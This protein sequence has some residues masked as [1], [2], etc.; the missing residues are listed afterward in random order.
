[1]DRNE[2]MPTTRLPTGVLAVSMFLAGGVLAW[3]TWGTWSVAS[4]SGV[5]LALVGAFLLLRTMIDWHNA[6]SASNRQ[7]SEQSEQLVALNSDLDQRIE[8][9]QEEVA[10]RI[11]AESRV[12]SLNRML[13]AIRDVNQLIARVT[14]RQR[15]LEGTC[16][17]LRNTRG[18]RHAWIALLDESHKLM[19][20]AE[21]GLDED[22]QALVAQMEAGT[23][24]AAVEQTLSQ[25]GVT[26]IEAPARAFGAPQMARRCLHEGCALAARL[27]CG[28]RI[29]G[30]MVACLDETEID[31]EELTLFGNTADD[32]AFALRSLEL[33][34]EQTRA[35][36]ALRLERSKLEGLL[37]LSQMT[38][39]ST[40]EI[41]EF[42][43]EEAVRLTQSEIGYLAFTNDEESVLT[44]H[45]WSKSAMDQCAVIDKP[46]VYPIETTGLWG[47]A[48]RQRQPV[49]TNDYPAPNPL[50]KGHPEG[51]VPI[52]RHMNIPVFD[53]EKIVAVAGVGNK[54]EPYDQSDVQQ[55]QLLTQAMWR[56]L[57]RQHDEQA[58]REAHEKLEQ[59]VKER[60]TELAD[61]NEDLKREI[62]E[63][64]RAEEV[65]KNSQALYSSLVENLPLHVI[66]KDLDGHFTF[67]NRSAC[68]LIGLPHDEVLGKTD[69]DFYP[70][71]LAAKYRDDDRRVI[72]TGELLDTVE[73]NR[74]DGQT[75]YVQV[76]KSAVKDAL[77]KTIGV[78]VIFWDVTE[79]KK[80][81]AALEQERYLLHALMDNLPHNI[82]FKDQDSRFI[83][84]NKA[85]SEY[86]GLNDAS[87]AIGKTDFDMF[88][89]EHAQQARDDELEIMRTEKPLLDREE[90]ETWS[91]GHTT[92]AT[93]TKMPLY[94][95][96]GRVVGTFGISRDITGQKRAAEALRMAKEAAEAANRA[97][98]EFLANVSHEVR[99][100]MNAIIGMTEL[101]LDSDLAESQREYLELVLE[102]AESL[103]SLIND[104]LDFSKIE[105]G[106]LELDFVEFDP[107]EALGDMM[108]SL[109]LRAHTKGLE[110]AWSMQSDVPATLVGDPHRL[111]QVLVNLAGNAIKFT[112]AG[113]VV[114]E[115]ECHSRSEHD[116]MLHFTVTDTG[117]GIPE[118]KLDAIFEKFQQVDS[119]TTR[120]FGGTG[121]G[122]AISSRLVELMGGHV[123]VESILGQ[124][125]TF[126]FSCRFGIVEP[127]HVP[128]PRAES[129][130]G[131]RVLIVDDNAT[132]RRILDAMVGN[133]GMHPTTASGADEAIDRIRDAQKS[134]TPFDLILSDVNMPEHDGFSLVKRIRRDPDSGT[135]VVMML[136]SSDQ[137]QHVAQCKELS[138]SAYL[139]KPVKQS[140]LF[141]AIALAVGEATAAKE[142]AEHDAAESPVRI[143]HLRV[144]L[145]ED[146]LVN[147]RL[148]V[149]L[150]KKWE[151][152]VLVANN[153][154]EAIGILEAQS[155]DVV[156][157]D[158]QMPEMDGFEATQW[159]REREKTEGGHLPVIAMTAHA[160]KGDRERC[161]KA[162]MDRYVS[163]PIRSHELRETIE[164]LF[165]NAPVSCP[166]GSSRSASPE[167]H[168]IESS[169]QAVQ[170]DWSSVFR[171]IGSDREALTDIVHIVRHEEGPQLF[172][173]IQAGLECGDAHRVHRAAHTLKGA[174]A[175]FGIQSLT[176]ALQ[177]LEQLGHD[178]KLDQSEAVWSAVENGWKH[179]LAALD[180]FAPDQFQ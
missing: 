71:E 8:Q 87:E 133:W 128:V 31:E 92:W 177:T 121:L 155:V 130:R 154:K 134:N 167:P 164:E 34:E 78:Q 132:N 76:M 37:K 104:I 29:F 158:V 142:T 165:A 9:L 144:L 129:L 108:R 41:T 55:L 168:S 95:D 3:L 24:I 172:E 52:Q 107:R 42:A 83:R 67:V 49:I 176:E 51:H 70:E 173:E 53:G 124:G 56:L 135:P 127:M 64:K 45:A 149:D 117:I 19:A 35:E 33:D 32:V 157:M 113:E 169:S 160:M 151:H 39:A 44:M 15:L 11:Q 65:I 72:E 166:E 63:R 5:V 90:K 69:F 174:V 99:T 106:K 97:K 146:S 82:Y 10:D 115:V 137:S 159:I 14:S 54:K 150:L 110:L 25:P 7:L 141:D 145:A 140:D 12:R 136:T 21:A 126:H 98:S 38:E 156:L 86:F 171:N 88:T 123:W 62:A 118:D 68:E 20:S 85:L 93:T 13:R 175:I 66:R 131:L 111:R 103:L 46:I 75:R 36:Q 16:R 178:R 119:T 148:A 57:Q 161:L 60:T 101:V 122:L 147:Q 30:V 47:E 81:I 143:R 162:G 79:N 180:A 153:G 102:S 1:M 120:Q 58:L 27:E 105:A 96:E 163:K 17:S 28:E 2:S 89:N 61:A 152:T 125:S 80:A 116:V 74:Q 22:F 138:I 114:V 77:G 91:N 84:I 6:L 23:P 59:R 26:V 179:F 170:I 4:V 100:P 94:D 40:E 18:Y 43:L 109:A 50:K 139:T 112:N 73:E 48:I